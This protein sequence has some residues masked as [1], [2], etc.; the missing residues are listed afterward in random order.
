M[1]DKRDVRPLC[2]HRRVIIVDEALERRRLE[3]KPAA[4]GPFGRGLDRLRDRP[5]APDRCSRYRARRCRRPRH[6]A[7]RAGAARGRRA[8]RTPSRPAEAELD[9]RRTEASRPPQAT[10]RSWPQHRASTRSSRRPATSKP[11]PERRSR[12]RARK[13]VVLVNAELDATLGP[14]LRQRAER[15]ESLFRTPTATSRG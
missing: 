12:H 4:G 8:D 14:I 1:F 3:G 6:G 9:A 5:T 11:A 7:G 15:P 13:H 2:G 10:R